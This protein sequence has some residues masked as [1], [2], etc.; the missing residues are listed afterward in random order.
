MA[1]L[2]RFLVNCIAIIGGMCFVFLTLYSWRYT[3]CLG[4]MEI[5]TTKADSLVLHVV[6]LLM[7][8]VGA[9]C[10]TKLEKRISERMIHGIAVG[11]AVALTTVMAVAAHSSIYFAQAD[12][13]YV[14]EAARQMAEDFFDVDMM[15][16]YFR[17]Y[18]HQL[19]L[20]RM[21]AALFRIC[22]NDGY[23]VI[24]T[25]NAV[26]VGICVYVGYRIVKEL[27]QTKAAQ[28]WYL[29]FILLFLPL[30]LYAFFVYGESIGV[31]GALTTI[32]AFLCY[33]RENADSKIRFIYVILAAFALSVAYITRT[34]L[35][36]VWIAMMIVQ[37]L[38]FLTDKRWKRLLAT[39]LLIVVAVGSASVLRTSVEREYDVRLEQGMP[40][41]LWIAM[42]LQD[43]PEPGKGQGAY[44]NYAW[45]LHQESGLDQ[46]ASDRQAKAYI[47]ERL[48]YFGNHPKEAVFFFKEKLLNQWIEPTYNVFEMTD[49]FEQMPGWVAFLY[50]EDSVEKISGW[51]NEYQAVA[52]AV[53]LGYFGWIIIQKRSPRECLI[54]L[55][56]LGEVI[57]S[58]IWEAKG[59]YVYPYMVIAIPLIAGCLSMYGT[60]LAGRVWKIF[61]KRSNKNI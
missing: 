17:V 35:I 60:Y 52:Y 28:V 31:A 34:A 56:L 33:N 47:G 14:Y 19:G 20:V 25:L 43:H 36:V 57:F 32:W 53:L 49:S 4:E 23:E 58:V 29:L 24:Q 38:L 26:C 6:V 50:E 41:T 42:G 51:L 22:G 15:S 2:Q 8:S 46:V 30:P 44:N 5:L 39:V 21:Y 11:L 40:V 18:P 59:R 55:I 1:K 3:K 10:L 37:V 9:F 7:I 54:G 45:E 13:F 61:Q 27:F 48:Q 16:S 12:Q